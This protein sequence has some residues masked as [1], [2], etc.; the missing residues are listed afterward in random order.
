MGNDVLEN[1]NG[2][3]YRVIERSH[4]DA[5]GYLLCRFSVPLCSEWTFHFF[6]ET[7]RWNC[8]MQSKPRRKFIRTSYSKFEHFQR[9]RRDY[10]LNPSVFASLLKPLQFLSGFVT[11]NRIAPLRPWSH[12]TNHR[13]PLRRIN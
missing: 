11:N 13:F 9:P 10:H 12:K 5:E 4:P 2:S 1:A 6:S 8:R 3:S 7:L